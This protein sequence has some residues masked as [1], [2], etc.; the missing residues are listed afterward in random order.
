MTKNKLANGQRAKSGFDLIRDGASV[1]LRNLKYLGETDHLNCPICQ[2]PFLSPMTTACG[3]TFCRECIEEC[4]KANSTSDEDPERGFCP[5]DRTAIDASDIND[6][7]P[8]PLIVTNMVDDLRVSCLNEERGCNW[9]GHRWEIDHHVSHECGYTRVHCNGV[10]STVTEASIENNEDEGGN[11]SDDDPSK[12]VEY[13]CKILT[14]RRFLG[15]SDGECVHKV[16]N[17][18]LCEEEITKINQQIHLDQSCSKNYAK[19]DVCENDMIQSKNLEKHRTN[20]L[21]SGRF[22]CTANEIGCTWS[23]DT[24]PSLENHL[25]NGNC[26]LNQIFPYVKSL[27]NKIND[28]VD[29]NRVLKKQINLILD[30]IVQGKVT[31]LG[32]NQ[33]IEEIG[34]FARDLDKDRLIN[35]NYEVERLRSELEEKVNPFIER[36]SGEISNRLNIMNNLVNDNF[37]MKDEMN[38][39]RALLN[40][41]RK[42]VQFIMFRNRNQTMFKGSSPHSSIPLDYE[43]PSFDLSSRSSSEERLNLKL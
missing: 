6:L 35:I 26:Q 3:H 25:Q 16:F 15:E 1:D 11:V 43:E 13:R 23:G 33:H 28:I 2:Q 22:V 12:R 10:R 18:D 40:S 17:C 42:Q 37:L 24:E 27:E 14:E 31:N 38:L 19:C 41:V 20:C 4:F 7:F 30:G 39:Q 29:E 8:A 5:L 9:E 34:S 21:K 32:Y 36:E